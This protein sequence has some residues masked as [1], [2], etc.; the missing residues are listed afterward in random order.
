MR[1]LK[2]DYNN[3]DYIKRLSLYFDKK[4]QYTELVL[5]ELASKY[6]F[7]PTFVLTLFAQIKYPALLINKGLKLSN[8]S[9]Q[10]LFQI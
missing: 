6:F 3:R 10:I 8:V 7:K 1:L 2:S 4:S 9:W 5:N